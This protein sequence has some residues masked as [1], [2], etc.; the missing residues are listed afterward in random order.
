MT[1]PQ[2]APAVDPDRWVAVLVATFLTATVTNPFAVYLIGIAALP[3]EAS[4]AHA[5]AMIPFA[6]LIPVVALGLDLWAI[7]KPR[8]AGWTWAVLGLPAVALVPPTPVAGL[9]L[10]LAGVALLELRSTALPRPGWGWMVVFAT[11]VAGGAGGIALLL[12]LTGG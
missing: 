8:P 12:A 6:L 9:P 5:I 2:P 1:R 10:L 7:R 4:E 11:Y 3:P